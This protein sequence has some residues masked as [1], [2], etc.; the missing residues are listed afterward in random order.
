MA[1]KWAL[2]DVLQKMTLGCWSTVSLGIHVGCMPQNDPSW[3]PGPKVLWHVQ[4]DLHLGRVGPGGQREMP[5]GMPRVGN[6]NGDICV[7]TGSE[8]LMMCSSP[9]GQPQW[10]LLPRLERDSEQDAAMGGVQRKEKSMCVS[11]VGQWRK[12]LKAEWLED[13]EDRLGD[14]GKGRQGVWSMARSLYPF[15]CQGKSTQDFPNLDFL[16]PSLHWLRFQKCWKG[17]AP[18]N[19]VE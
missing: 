18:W 16:P 14:D 1:G 19:H 15:Q 11:P 12:N 7:D 3:G 17:L 4:P 5:A 10:T 6:Q 8:H 13:P 2:L 9:N